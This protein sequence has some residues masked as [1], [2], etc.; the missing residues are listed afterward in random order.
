MKKTGVVKVRK[1]DCSPKEERKEMDGTVVDLNWD[2]PAK[3][4]G[5]ETFGYVDGVTTL[6]L[7][8][9]MKVNLE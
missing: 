1:V 8:G 3:K 9:I 6:Q 4:V 7:D 2:I 5:A